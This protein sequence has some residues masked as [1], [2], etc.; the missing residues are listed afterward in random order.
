M[1]AMWAPTSLTGHGRTRS[2]NSPRRCPGA[3]EPGNCL[4]TATKQARTPTTEG[5]SAMPSPDSGNQI[6]ERQRSPEATE[7]LR[8]FHHAHG[9]AKHWH[10]ARL[11]GTV[12][13]ALS[14][15]IVI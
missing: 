13:V 10:M 15:P 4:P 12:L 7:L 14:A 3:R 1:K 9:T 11:A 8:A 6:A 2:P 5:Y